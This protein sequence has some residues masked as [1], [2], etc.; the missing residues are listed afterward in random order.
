MAFWSADSSS[1]A[2]EVAAGFGHCR[3]SARL[4]EISKFFDGTDRIH[5]AMRRVVDLF[6]ANQIAYAIVGGMAVNAHHHART[7]QDVDFLVRA[8]ALTVIRR[9]VGQGLLQS[10]AGRSRRFLEPSTGVQFDVLISGRFPGNG[11]PGPIAFP[12]PIAVGQSIDDFRVVNLTTLIELKLAAHR[13]QDLADVVNL[14]RVNGL[15]DTFAERLH[16]SVRADFVECLEEKRRED[17]YESRQ[18]S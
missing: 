15:D 13:Y 4:R 5:Q 9:L 10:E 6:N 8:E 1:N 12:D 11:D 16:P 18:E 7:T 17:D 3:F 14:I 2:R